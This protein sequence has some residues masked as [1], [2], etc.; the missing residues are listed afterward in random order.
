MMSLT[1]TTPSPY[2]IPFFFVLR[3]AVFHFANLTIVRICSLQMCGSLH[4]SI[5]LLRVCV[6]QLFFFFSFSLFFFSPSTFLVCCFFCFHS[7]LLLWLIVS[8]TYIN[9]CNDW[10][11]RTQQRK[12]K[13][14]SLAV[15]FSFHFCSISFAR[16]LVGYI[17]QLEKKCSEK[18]KTVPNKRTAI[19]YTN[20]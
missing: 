16:W 11:H 18:R 15:F 19:R 5:S 9:R 12:I 8:S 14:D 1:T 6:G 17:S 4:F 3:D 10:S 20:V 13:N 7:L 2:S